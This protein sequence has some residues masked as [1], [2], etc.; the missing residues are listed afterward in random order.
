M[1]LAKILTVQVSLISK[2]AYEGRA[3]QAYRILAEPIRALPIC[4]GQHSTRCLSL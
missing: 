1:A 4:A 3:L 2:K